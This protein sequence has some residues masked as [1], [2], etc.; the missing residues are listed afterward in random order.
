M[1]SSIPPLPKP[2][3]PRARLGFIAATLSLVAIFAASGSPIPLYERYRAQ[4]GLTTTDL[5]IA[6]VSYFVAVMV[7]LVVFGRLSDHLSRRAV[8]L[9]A[10][11]TVL[12]FSRP[13]RNPTTQTDRKNPCRS[14]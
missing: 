12:A 5:S 9:I 3:I 6:A 13:G 4:D 14:H 8:A 2:G 1:T 7:S 11:T 10:T